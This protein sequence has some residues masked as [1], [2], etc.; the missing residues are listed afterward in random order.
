MRRPGRP[1]RRRRK[2]SV[3]T[4]AEVIIQRLSAVV[5]PTLARAVVESYTDEQRRFIAGD[6]GPAELNGGRVCEAVSRCLLQMDTG[7]LTH[8]FLPGAIR[9][10]LLDESKSHK[11]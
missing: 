1:R 2:K 9:E 5:D 6:H 4:E 8:R 3:G 7:K 10:I 11:L